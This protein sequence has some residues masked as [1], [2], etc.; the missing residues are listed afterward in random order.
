VGLG[1]D[2]PT[3][4]GDLAGTKFS[5]LRQINTGNVSQLGQVWAVGERWNGERT[6][7]RGQRLGVAVESAEEVG[8]VMRD[9]LYAPLG[10]EI[11]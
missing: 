5:A 8:V 9:G 1:S 6:E 10:I 4:S 7:F 3:Y 11:T 2:W